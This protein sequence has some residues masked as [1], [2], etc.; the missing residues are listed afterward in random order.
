MKQVCVGAGRYLVMRAGWWCWWWYYY[1]RRATHGKYYDDN[2][3]GLWLS[4]TTRH[5]TTTTRQL[6]RH[7]ARPKLTV[8][9]WAPRLGD[10]KEGK[11]RS[12]WL[13]GYLEC[14]LVSADNQRS[15]WYHPPPPRPS[16]DDNDFRL[17]LSL[18]VPGWG[19]TMG[20]ICS[21]CSLYCLSA[22]I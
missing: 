12:G 17:S 9:L 10:Q 5:H 6:Y 3:P 19:V 22:H 21:V 4:Y 14:N 15:P 1:D 11:S 2:S 18:A 20:S 8:I 7:R 16:G 13:E